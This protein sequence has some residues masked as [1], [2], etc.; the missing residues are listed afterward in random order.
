MQSNPQPRGRRDVREAEGNEGMYWQMHRKEGASVCA[1]GRV[2]ATSVQS[3]QSQLKA[4]VLVSHQE[5]NV[6]KL[7]KHS[8]CVSELLLMQK[9]AQT[10]SAIITTPKPMWRQT[11]AG[12]QKKVSTNRLGKMRKQIMGQKERLQQPAG[13]RR[14]LDTRGGRLDKSH[15]AQIRVH[16]LP[17]TPKNTT[18]IEILCIICWAGASTRKDP[19]KKNKKNTHSKMRWWYNTKVAS[20]DSKSQV[21]PCIFPPRFHSISQLQRRPES[22]GN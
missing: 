7:I 17:Q 19:V 8:R 11:S 6:S 2:P 18:I 15:L 3:E 13:E 12:R 22:Q 21:I 4:A 16:R 1:E 10:H 5:G 9:A 14:H 20:W